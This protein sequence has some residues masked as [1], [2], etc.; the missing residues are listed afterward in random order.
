MK[1]IPA[2]LLASLMVGVACSGSESTEPIPPAVNHDAQGS[3]GQNNDGV[4]VPGNSLVI[5]MTESSGTIAGSGS[6]AGEAGPYGSLSLSGTVVNGSLH[7]RIIYVYEPHVFPQL[8]SDTAQ[9]VGR[10]TNRDHVD[11][12]LTRRGVDGPFRLVRLGGPYC[13]DAFCRASRRSRDSSL[14]W[15]E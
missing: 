10:L 13:V 1:F 8:Q 7:L 3:W 15:A 2:L 11:G 4:V 9:F 14:T 12:I 5:A 6:F